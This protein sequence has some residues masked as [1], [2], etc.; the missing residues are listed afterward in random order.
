M[1]SILLNNISLVVVSKRERE[2]EIKSGIVLG[3]L[4]VLGSHKELI[5]IEVPTYLC[6]SSL[7]LRK[8]VP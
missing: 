3:F 7:V 8:E 1:M 5:K 2:R 4:G 6:S